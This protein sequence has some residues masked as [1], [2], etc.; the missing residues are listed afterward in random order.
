MPF[1]SIL[2]MIDTF[3]LSSQMVIIDFLLDLA[4]WG[5]GSD[6]YFQDVTY[7]KYYFK[8]SVR[9]PVSVFLASRKSVCF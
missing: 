2:S 8:D 6:S 1:S 5:P 3:V 7:I 9:C 4:A